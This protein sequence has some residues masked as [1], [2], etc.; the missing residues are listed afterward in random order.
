MIK[1]NSSVI[2]S[3]VAVKHISVVVM[4][5]LERL[6]WKKECWRYLWSGPVR[7]LDGNQRV[8]RDV[9]TAAQCMQCNASNQDLH[10]FFLC[11]TQLHLLPVH[12]LIPLGLIALIVNAG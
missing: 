6:H 1:I 9:A 2:D 3:M 7:A 11:C 12:T 8:W 4:E 5:R 10:S